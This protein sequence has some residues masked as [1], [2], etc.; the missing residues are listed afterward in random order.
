MGFDGIFA[1]EDYE[2]RHNP[3]NEWKK[4]HTVGYLGYEDGIALDDMMKWVDNQ[5]MVDPCCTN[6]END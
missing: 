6:L 3:S 2:T 1:K 4:K 5:T